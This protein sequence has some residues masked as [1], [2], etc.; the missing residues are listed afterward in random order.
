LKEGWSRSSLTPRLSLT[1]SD[2]ERLF[3]PLTGKQAKIQ[4][5][6]LSLLENGFS[7]SNYRVELK[8]EIFG[9]RHFV[10]RLLEHGTLSDLRKE[11]KLNQMLKA[12]VPMPE[13]YLASDDNDVFS[14]V[15]YIIMEYVQGESLDQVKNLGQDETLSLAKSLGQ[16]LA[17][18]HQMRFASQGFLD[19]NL[20]VD[21]VVEI[22]GQGLRRFAENIL[23]EKGRAALLGKSLSR[24]FLAFLEQE[25]DLLDDYKDLPCLCHS[26]FGSSNLL[27]S[28]G[29]SPRVVA[30]LDFE[31]AFSGTPYVDLGNL[32]RPPFSQEKAVREA[33]FQGYRTGGGK[34]GDQD[35]YQKCLLTDLFAWLEFLGGAEVPEAV[36]SSVRSRIISTMTD[37]LFL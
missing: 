18:L 34:L 19:E 28:G 25:A 13:F 17:A 31:F 37:W 9:R 12:T 32:L 8:S 30:V 29:P 11:E 10:L 23:L 26:D 35:L 24:R 14:S 6:S 21:K 20:L 3:Q 15:P 2:A 16:T 27:I 5:E 36:L 7:N 33:V 22:N 1:A 4:V